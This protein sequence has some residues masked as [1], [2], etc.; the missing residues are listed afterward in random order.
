MVSQKHLIVMSHLPL[1]SKLENRLGTEFSSVQS[2]SCVRLFATPWTTTRQPSLSITSSW[3]LPKPMPIELV[4]P[5]NHLILCHPLLLLPSIF[6]HPDLELVIR[7][8]ELSDYIGLH[9]PRLLRDFVL[10]SLIWRVL[11][12]L[13]WDREGS[14]CSFSEVWFCHL[15][16]NPLSCCSVYER[17]CS[18]FNLCQLTASLCISQ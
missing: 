16:E 12:S 15:V 6:L 13:L 9:F 17:P 14:N 5:S 8:F 1:C 3:S 11:L 10:L 4:M 7:N 2:L 18:E